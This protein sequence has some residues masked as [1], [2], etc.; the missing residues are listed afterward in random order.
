MFTLDVVLLRRRNAKQI[1]P[2]ANRA[3]GRSSPRF[4]TSILKINYR[5]IAAE[6]DGARETGSEGKLFVCFFNFKITSLARAFG[7]QGSI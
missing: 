4:R 5:S 3:A 2:T 1:F 7:A 6:G